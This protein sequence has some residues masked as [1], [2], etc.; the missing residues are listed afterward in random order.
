[1]GT[2]IPMT[3]LNNTAASRDP[4]S[5]PLSHSIFYLKKVIV[6]K[7]TKFDLKHDFLRFTTLLYFKQILK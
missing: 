3:L 5:L 1:M 6:S 7:Q 2:T 4:S